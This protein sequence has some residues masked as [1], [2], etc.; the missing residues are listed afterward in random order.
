MNDNLFAFAAKS[1]AF[2]GFLAF[3]AFMM[4][5]TLWTPIKDPNRNLVLAFLYVSSAFTTLAG[6]FLLLS[7]VS[8]TRLVKTD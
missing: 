5:V 8:R 2:V 4:V 1:V 3:T 6:G 7:A